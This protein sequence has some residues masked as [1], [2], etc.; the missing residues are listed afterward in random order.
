[1]PVIEGGNII[2]GALTREGSH[3][4]IRVERTRI[5]RNEMLTLRTQSKALVAAPGSGRAIYFHGAM[6]HKSGGSTAYALA[7]ASTIRFAYGGGASPQAQFRT[8][9]LT[10]STGAIWVIV[11]AWSANSG[12]TEHP[13]VENSALTVTLDGSN[14]FTD[15]DDDQELLVTTYYQIAHT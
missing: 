12:A 14:D 9:R 4:D 3:G 5:P 13:V 7:A 2:E 10:Q 1:M 15:G 8:T 11:P 6:V